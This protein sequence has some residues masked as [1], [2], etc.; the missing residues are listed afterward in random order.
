M[1]PESLR[2]TKEHEWIGQQGDTW[3]VGISDFAQDQ[4]GDITYVELPRIGQKVVQND[5]A[6]TV[7][8]VKAA[9]DVYA[10]AGG[11]VAEVNE[12]LEATP[13]LINKD[14]FGEG[15]F[16]KLRDVDA[17]E[18]STLMDYAAYQKYASEQEH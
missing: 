4:L 2:F 13:E 9:S 15:W 7:E 17:A 5:Q 14:P 10:P 6:A 11:T 16:F 3:A 8:S 1:N 18:L 12:A